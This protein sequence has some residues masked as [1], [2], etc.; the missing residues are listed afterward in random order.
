MKYDNLASLLI[1][2]NQ[3]ALFESTGF[4]SWISWMIKRRS[5]THSYVLDLPPPPTE[6]QW[7]IYLGCSLHLVT[8]GNESLGWDSLLNNPGGDWHRGRG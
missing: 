4:M 6:Q 7:Y 1:V 2:D 5:L 3:H 8:E